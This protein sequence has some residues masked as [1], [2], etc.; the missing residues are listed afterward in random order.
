[1]TYTKTTLIG[2][3]ATLLLHG[4]A[5]AQIPA[6][7]IPAPQI[8]APMASYSGDMAIASTDGTMLSSKI[9]AGP[10]TRRVEMPTQNGIMVSIVNTQTQEVYSYGKDANGPMGTTAMKLKF[11]TETMKMAADMSQ[12]PNPVLSGSKAVAGHVCSVYTTSTGSAC[13]TGDGILLEALSNDGGSLT[14]T[15]LERGP[16]ASYLFRVPNGYQIHDMSNLAGALGG[17]LGGSGMGGSGMGGSG[18]GGS[19]MGG[20]G[21][22]GSGMG[23]TG[24]GGSGNGLQSFIE[25]QAEKQTKK[26]IQK[27]ARKQVGN[28]VGGAIGGG[29]VGGAVGN[30]AGKLAKGLVGGLFGKKKKKKKK[31][32]DDKK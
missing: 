21:M 13:V 31:K 6:P 24:M 1:M 7:Q 3:A 4:T 5:N 9:Y 26:Q 25:N 15:S 30:E 32:D 10:H 14:M 22:G 16:Q 23:E 19:G 29:I 11:D 2:L 28:T 27:A 8:P 18:M 12:E 20:S 17:S